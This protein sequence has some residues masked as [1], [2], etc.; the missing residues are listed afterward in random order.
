[1][2]VLPKRLDEKVARLHLDALGVKLTKLTDEQA[3]YLGVEPG[4]PL[5]ARA[6]PLLTRRDLRVVA[7]RS[8]TTLG[9]GSIP[10]LVRLVADA[11]PPCQPVASRLAAAASHAGQR[12]WA[13]VHGVGSTPG[14]AGLTSGRPGWTG[15]GR[16]CSCGC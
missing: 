16:T 5:Q 6:L 9:R 10:P 2:Y 12:P 7:V 4:R 11:R 15:T 3:E 13:A 1:M 14:S 8:V